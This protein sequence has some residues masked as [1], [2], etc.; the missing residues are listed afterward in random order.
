MNKDPL[1]LFSLAVEAAETGTMPPP[2]VIQWYQSAILTH[3]QTGESLDV[4]LGLKKRGS[5]SRQLRTVYL[6]KKR[7][8]FLYEAWT[9]SGKPTAPKGWKDFSV[10]VRR[11]CNIKKHPDMLPLSRALYEAHRIGPQIGN[12]K[13]L[14]EAVIA[15]TIQASAATQPPDAVKELDSE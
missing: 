11:A 2:E 6:L 1:I 7:N 14:R 8:R 3:L 4:L 12:W 5:K 10:R 15:A 13:V 9:L